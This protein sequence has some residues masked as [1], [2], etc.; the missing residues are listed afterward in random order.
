MTRSRRTMIALVTGLLVGAGPA[1]ACIP[2]PV[3]APP[4]AAAE[5]E[6]LYRHAA[7]VDLVK[8]T[9]LQAVSPDALARATAA[10]AG[11][12][13]NGYEYYL[14]LISDY[15]PATY[16]YQVLER[17]KGAPP[18]SD[19]T[20]QGMTQ[21]VLADDEAAHAARPTPL[22][23]PPVYAEP[24]EEATAENLARSSCALYPYGWVGSTAV[25]FRDADG[26]L[27][28]AVVPHRRSGQMLSGRTYAI[29]AG[30][31][32]RWLSQV[33]AAARRLGATKRGPKPAP[34]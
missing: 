22:K 13:G 25:V 6:A 32:D 7:Y 28:G 19:F 24:I 34:F 27:L 14:E 31:E 20:L 5:A 8:I 11:E 17:L 10:A 33:R 1:D 23:R 2:R 21:Q 30:G 12:G 4:T 9:A 15:A 3:R 16:H 29:V 26:A 18:P